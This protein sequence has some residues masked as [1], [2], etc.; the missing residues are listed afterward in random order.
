MLHGS[1]YGS[2]DD[3]DDDSDDD[4]QMVDARVEEIEVQ[5]ATVGG[6]RRAL[7]TLGEEIR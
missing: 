2:D 6:T 7:I 5:E 3:F 1:N 4:L